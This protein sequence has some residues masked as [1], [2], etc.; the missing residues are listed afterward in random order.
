M[1]EKFYEEETLDLREIFEVLM[2]RK[3]IIICVS[4][5]GF[6][7][8]FG[9]TKLCVPY[10]YTAY[11]SMYVKNATNKT[12]MDVVNQ[13]DITAAQQLATTCIEILSDDVVTD[14]LGT[15]LLENYT[16][17]ELAPYFAVEETSD[18]YRIAT[19]SI[20]GKLGYS[21]VNETELIRVTATCGDPIIAA[22]ICNY[23]TEIAPDILIRV[24]GAGAVEAVGEA[25][26]PEVPSAPSARKNAA[27][28]FVIG[29]VLAAGVVVL[30]FIF[31][32]TIKSGEDAADKFNLPLIGEIPFY[33]FNEQNGIKGSGGAF[34]KIKN[35]GKKAPGIDDNKERKTMLDVKVPFAVQEAY[36]TMR[37]NMLFSLS[38]GKENVFVVSSPLPGEGKSTSVANL[39]ISIGETAS[40]VLLV[41]ADLRKPVQHKMFELTNKEGL[42]TV[43]AGMCS[44]ENAVNKNVHQNLD[45]L[46]AG[47]VPPNP[48]QML[49][50]ENMVDFINTVK[51]KYDFVVIDTSPINVVSDALVISKRTAGLIL[52]TRQ[53]ITT[54][55]QVDRA[56]TSV[57][58]MDVNMLG[59]VVN[60]T[61]ANGSKYGRYGRYGKY[62]YS[63]KY[64]Y[65]EEN[66]EES[67]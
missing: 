41:D 12:A 11:V 34:N 22:D 27:V 57:K 32:N 18:G 30:K 56:M 58:M 63:Y 40:R 31:D 46:T 35:F 38:T 28:G 13:S 54:Y 19:A 50:S 3:W 29:F 26:I 23:V 47:P 59:I 2:A 5:L 49:A 62:G 33:E 44:L 48:S 43:L 1:E 39:C 7:L 53:G 61:E 21:T 64:G 42:S 37:N 65:S 67:N 6:V 15:K 55:D 20:A 4:V 24:V 45:V 36:N 60:S 10:Q 66:K 25:K 51:E 8:A 17:E 9:Y 16:P 14:S 52:V